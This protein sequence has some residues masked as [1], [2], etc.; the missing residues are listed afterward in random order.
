MFVWLTLAP[1]HSAYSNEKIDISYL[2]SNPWLSSKTIIKLFGIEGI[3][4]ISSLILNAF[5]AVRLISSF[6]CVF[7][8]Y[9][10]YL[11]KSMS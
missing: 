11:R 2:T 7:K 6:L 4:T 8:K 3:K 5:V 9:P 10:F 1:V